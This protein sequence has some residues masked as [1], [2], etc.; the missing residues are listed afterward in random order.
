M[1]IQRLKNFYHFWVALAANIF[2][3]FP[4]KK[5]FVIGVTGTNGKTTT[6]QMIGNILREAGYKAGVTSTIDFQIGAKKQVNRTKLTT[7]GPLAHQNFLARC[8]KGKCQFAVIEVSSHSLDQNRAWGTDYDLGVITNVTREH[9][10]YHRTMRNYRLAKLKMFKYLAKKRDSF[11]K[12]EKSGFAVV[13]FSMKNPKEFILSNPEKTY[14]YSASESFL[15][16][17]AISRKYKNFFQARNILINQNGS[18]F[19]LEKEEYELN[20]P[21]LFNVENALAA[22]CVGKILGIK[23]KI[24]KEALISLKKLPGRME[25]VL[26]DKGVEIIIDYALTPDSM[27]KVGKLLRNKLKKTEA[28]KPLFYW[29]FGSCGQ[30]DRGKRPLMGRIAAKY[31]DKIIITNE[32]PYK[33]DP[34]QIIDEVFRG[35]KDGGKTEG[36]DA[37]R[38]EDRR[39]A[40]KKALSLVREGDLLLVTGKGA[41]ENMKIGNK[42]IEWNDRKVIEELL[43]EID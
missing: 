31:A 41:E 24:I 4:S 34:R 2:Y 18:R 30:R 25:K 42:L 14:L 26:N 33:E 21:G 36:K 17:E 19:N 15:E 6:V 20:L 22:I 43:E 3:G 12:G 7:M 8:V 5:L 39:L 1:L 37:F 27:E 32:D 11:K 38:L 10:D 23:E 28:G 29:V 9:L 16:K 35:V 13:N 40:L